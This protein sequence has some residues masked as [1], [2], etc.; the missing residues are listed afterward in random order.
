MNDIRTNCICATLHWTR[1]LL[2]WNQKRIACKQVSCLVTLYITTSNLMFS[3][4]TSW[5]IM[6]WDRKLFQYA[7]DMQN[8]H[9]QICTCF[10]R[11]QGWPNLLNVRATHDKIQMSE[12]R[13][14]WIK[15]TRFSSIQIY[16]LFLHTDFV[17]IFLYKY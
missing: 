13:K 9:L 1:S 4:T 6:S 15:F 7:T 8:H 12:S 16:T 14:T 2:Q 3:N 11:C 5:A 10:D 17:T